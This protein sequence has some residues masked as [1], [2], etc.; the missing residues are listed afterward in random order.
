MPVAL[1]RADGVRITEKPRR[2]VG[3]VAHHSSTLRDETGES[4]SVVWGSGAECL[5]CVVLVDESRAIA[6]EAQRRIG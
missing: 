6:R 1:P 4:L 2:C 3:D 5:L